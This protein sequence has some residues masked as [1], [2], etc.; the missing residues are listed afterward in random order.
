L[1]VGN[2]ST[3]KLELRNPETLWPIEQD[4]PLYDF[5][6]INEAPLPRA[7]IVQLT[8]DSTKRLASLEIEDQLHGI[9]IGLL[10]ATLVR[11][12]Q[13]ACNH[14]FCNRLA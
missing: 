8:L 12:Q 6:F 13:S 2:G 7:S 3:E 1:R 14:C 10:G 9:E 4:Y 5:L 11:A